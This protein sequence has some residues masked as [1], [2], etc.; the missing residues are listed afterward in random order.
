MTD[1]STPTE[2]FTDESLAELSLGELDDLWRG[3]IEK[4]EGVRLTRSQ[5]IQNEIR[6]MKVDYAIRQKV[7]P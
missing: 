2:T 3:L 5:S 6:L 1:A 4:N 7:Q